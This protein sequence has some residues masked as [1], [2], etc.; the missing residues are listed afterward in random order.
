MKIY[1][2][3]TL[4]SWRPTCTWRLNSASRSRILEVTVLPRRDSST[5]LGAVGSSLGGA[6][7][8]RGGAVWK[9]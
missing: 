2:L 4:R 1:H 9:V 3:A 6:D 5:L 7:W 8:E